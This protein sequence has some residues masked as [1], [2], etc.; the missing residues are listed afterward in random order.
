MVNGNRGDLKSQTKLHRQTP[1]NE[2]AKHR[3][4]NLHTKEECSI[5]L[6]GGRGMQFL[7]Q[8][9]FRFGGRRDLS[10]RSKEKLSARGSLS[11]NTFTK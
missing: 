4:S 9:E 6:K 7:N 2:D 10:Q 1:G 3:G 5:C 8:K 11:V